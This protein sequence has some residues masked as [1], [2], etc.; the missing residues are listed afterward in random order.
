MSYIQDPLSTPERWYYIYKAFYVLDDDSGYEDL[1]AIVAEV[2]N[3]LEKSPT[4][5]GA[6]RDFELELESY[7][8]DTKMSEIIVSFIVRLWEDDD[9]EIQLILSSISE[10]L[11]GA[12]FQVEET[13]FAG[14][15]RRGNF[16]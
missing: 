13:E 11:E 6:A 1:D 3:N 7:D 16:Y 14:V 15:G 12:G 10:E 2:A 5:A 8:E 4:H 9:N